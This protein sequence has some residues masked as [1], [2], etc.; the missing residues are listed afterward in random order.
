MNY[1]TKRTASSARGALQRRTF[2][3]CSRQKHSPSNGI[4]SCTEGSLLRFEDYPLSYCST[5]GHGQLVF[6]HRPL[7][8]QEA[9]VCSRASRAVDQGIDSGTSR[10]AAQHHRRHRRQYS[11]LHR[12]CWS[13]LARK[14]TRTIPGCREA[15]AE[16]GIK[17]PPL[18]RSRE[19]THV[20]LSLP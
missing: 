19:Q 14:T 3:D 1:V 8:Q 16:H 17:H 5:D 13:S 4:G 20:S 7:C 18:G 10:V 15:M 9:R 6:T 11:V 12:F 2:F